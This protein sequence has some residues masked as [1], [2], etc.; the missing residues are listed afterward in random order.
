M[1]IHSA[2]GRLIKIS[3]IYY[4]IKICAIM[5]QMRKIGFEKRAVWGFSSVKRSP[6]FILKVCPAQEG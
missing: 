5:R 2:G 3:V 6:S 1:R 4:S